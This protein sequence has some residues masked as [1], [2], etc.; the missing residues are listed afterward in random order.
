MKRNDI[1]E[2]KFH[3]YLIKIVISEKGVYKVQGF[4]NLSETGCL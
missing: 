3:I 4:E 2:W 1:S